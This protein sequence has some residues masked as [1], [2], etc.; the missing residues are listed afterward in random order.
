ML[1]SRQSNARERQLHSQGYKTKRVR[2]PNGDEVVLKNR[3]PW[4]PRQKKS[5]P[6]I[7]SP[8]AI[9]ALGVVGYFAI[10]AYVGASVSK[11]I[12]QAFAP[13]KAA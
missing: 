10:K 2:L 1:T 3:P 11:D 12:N 4:A 6:L 5:E 13:A 7:S 9:L 8:L